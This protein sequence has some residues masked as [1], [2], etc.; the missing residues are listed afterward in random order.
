MSIAERIQA[1]QSLADQI[2]SELHDL[3]FSGTLRSRL[4]AACYFASLDHQTGIAVLFER[5]IQSPALALLRP[6]FESYIRACWLFDGATEVQIGF[7]RERKPIPRIETLVTHLEQ[8]EPFAGVNALSASHTR[9]WKT[10]CGFTHGGIE[11][12][13][14]NMS[15]D[16]IERNCPDD[17]VGEA[18]AFADAIALLSA[19]GVARIADNRALAMRLLDLLKRRQA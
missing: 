10:L 11:L 19:V 2:S 14:R 4:S 5:G 3:E 9:N 17:E 15:A 18:L 1:S 16:S 13:M 12:A 6:L 8:T 7:Y